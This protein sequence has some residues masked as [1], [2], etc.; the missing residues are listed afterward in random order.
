[1]G[2]RPDYA[3][4]IIAIRGFAEVLGREIDRI[5]PEFTDHSIRH[6]DCMWWVADEVI[7]ENE[8][9]QLSAGES[10][11]LAGAFY[12]HDL[13]MAFAA[14]SEGVAALRATPAYSAAF[15]RL[16]R[17][18]AIAPERA[19]VLAIRLVS[20]E[21][22]AQKALELATKPIPGLERYLIEDS[23]FRKRWSHLLGQI[24]ESHHWG[25][26]QVHRILGSR[27]A[28][29]TSDG[30]LAD[31]GYVA[32]LLRIVDYAHVNS[33]R[34][35]D[36]ERALR[37]EINPDSSVHW[38]AQANITGPSRQQDELV[39]S[40]TS[41]I[42]D[43]DA[44]WLFFDTA[45]GLN[46]EIRSVREYLKSRSI[47][48]GRFSL[49]GVRGVESPQSFTQ[50][51]QLAGDTVPIDV[52]VQ[53]HSMERVVELLGGKQLYGADG[54][55][56]LRELIQ[57]ARDA[58]S[59]RTAVDQ[60]NGA[61]PSEGRISITFHEEK[62]RSILAIRDNGIGMKRDVVVRHLIGVGSDFW[63]SAEFYRDFGK[64]E[65]NG[66][67]PIGKFGIG[68]LSV[69][70]LGDYIEVETEAVGAPR[71]KLTL[72]GVGRRGHLSE[73][74]STGNI[75]TE[76]KVRLNPG[77][78][79]SATRLASVVRA[80]APMLGVPIDIAVRSSGSVVSETIQPGWWKHIDERDL[81]TFVKT[82]HSYAYNGREPEPN[83]DRAYRYYPVHTGGKFDL[84][85][86]PGPNPQLLSGNAR[87]VSG[88]GETAYGV[89][90]CSQGIAIDVAHHADVTG[91]MEIGRVE[92]TASRESV[93]IGA[94]KRGYRRQMAGEDEHGRALTE[95]LRSE[96]LGK[97][98]DLDRFGMI[99]ARLRFLRYLGSVYGM[100][101]LR[102]TSARW[103]PV[104]EPPGNIIHRSFAE[105]VA[106][107][108]QQTR[109]IVGTGL[110]HA[111]AYSI[112]VG[113]IPMI[114]LGQTLAVA[115]RHE[116]IDIGYSDKERLKLE[117]AGSIVDTFDGVIDKLPA[118]SVK[119]EL[120]PFLLELIAEAWEL[121]QEKIRA[122]EWILDVENEIFWSLLSRGVEGQDGLRQA[123]RAFP[124]K[125]R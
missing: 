45:S 110:S 77:V 83:G 76:V 122:Q 59:L 29:P 7:T 82:W 24:S 60:S 124:W 16:Q 27:N 69:F 36:L 30:E 92:L 74:P 63:H 117:H 10:L 23:E 51:V 121:P 109:L 108:A 25:L 48:S 9:Q 79:L 37:S 123:A 67:E 94:A 101:L 102:E 19:D 73:T 114:E 12:L 64:A 115:F 47:S 41:P 32:C 111:S 90:R 22:H 13:G 87:A 118:S 96:V 119:L 44:W 3:N 34:A 43:V 33:D 104:L 1:M 106:T 113:R 14:T 58:I 97:L 6:M 28:T 42:A 8:A 26:D 70:M 56:P 31:L 50:Y 72:R 66:F 52:R 65:E 17:A 107:L 98:N 61:R 53:P 91:I 68:F 71:V 4:A 21:L 54:M 81:M 86:W 35:D 11:L 2:T 85:G 78:T 99:P 39:Y 88:G 62:E 116:E 112:A 40:C 49:Q 46:N 103:I 84:M 105:L 120:L 125:T 15:Q 55:A 57:N 20:R 89:L 38:N 18:G 5:I 80:R 95:A 100:A 75:G 93:D